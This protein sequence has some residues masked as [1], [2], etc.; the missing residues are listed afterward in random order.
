MVS[1]LWPVSG[2]GGGAAA[3]VGPILHVADEAALLALPSVP[4]RYVI[5][6][7]TQELLI[8]AGATNVLAAWAH[9]SDVDAYEYELAWNDG[10]MM[11]WNDGREVALGVF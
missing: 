1:F 9:V 10:A 4:R 7:D 3:A 2:G 6:D 11:M 5:R 8:Q